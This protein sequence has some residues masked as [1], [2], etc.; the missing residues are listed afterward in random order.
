M[1]V[2]HQ[3][4]GALH[5]VWQGRISG[6]LSE[7]AIGN[8]AIRTAVY[9]RLPR[10]NDRAVTEADFYNAF[11][12]VFTSPTAALGHGVGG[13]PVGL[14]AS[15]AGHRFRGHSFH[16]SWKPIEFLP[17]VEQHQDPADMQSGDWTFH[18]T[19]MRTEEVGIAVLAAQV[20][21]ARRAYIYVPLLDDASKPV[22]LLEDGVDWTEH[23][24]IMNTRTAEALKEAIARLAA[25]KSEDGQNASWRSVDNL[26]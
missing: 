1:V 16:Y 8:T 25:A 13:F 4:A 21:Q 5:R 18:H 6:S 26:S 24:E 19:I 23:Q 7:A 12:A 11:L 10:Q 20:Q 15:P 17:G 9:D 3:P 2:S 14:D 22:A